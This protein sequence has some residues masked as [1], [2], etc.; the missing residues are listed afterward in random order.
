MDLFPLLGFAAC[1]LFLWGRAT[2]DTTL[3]TR[4][5]LG[6]R[7]RGQFEFVGGGYLRGLFQIYFQA[8]DIVSADGAS[9]D[10]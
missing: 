5:A 8:G 2:G 7:V 6:L 9:V 10:L 4:N 3:E 1:C